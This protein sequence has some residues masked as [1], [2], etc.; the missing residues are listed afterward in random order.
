[1]SNLQLA[2]I[3]HGA[4][5]ISASS[6]DN[7]LPPN[8][9]IDGKSNTY[10]MSTGSFP[11]EII[12]QLGEPSLVKSVELISTG[13]RNI[14][15]SKCEGAQANTWEKVSTSEAD[16]A[17]GEIQRLT[18]NIPARLQATFLRIRI[19]SGWCDYVSLYKLSVI[20]SSSSSLNSNSSRK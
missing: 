15:L 4:S 5:I 6:C 16:D 2:T 20:G 18:L 14:E 3:T 7:R 1:M 13:L 11:Q 19:T 8:S 10:W 9:I 17:D 12:L